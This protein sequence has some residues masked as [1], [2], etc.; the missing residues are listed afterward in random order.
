[1]I[2]GATELRLGDLDG[3]F[4]QPIKGLLCFLSC[5]I[6]ITI[7]ADADVIA[8]DHGNQVGAAD[9]VVVQPQAWEVGEKAGVCNERVAAIEDVSGLL[10]YF[11]AYA[12]DLRVYWRMAKLSL[13]REGGKD[14]EVL[15]DLIADLSREIEKRETHQF[16]NWSNNKII[17][18]FGKGDI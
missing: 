3:Q 15:V 1:M 14:E 12:E 17:C 5:E 10:M 11:A 13:G 8:A 2:V 7:E 6:G 16:A 9:G 18:F 4:L